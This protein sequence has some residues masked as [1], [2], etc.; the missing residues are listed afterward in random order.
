MLTRAL[1]ELAIGTLFSSPQVN[2]DLL[3]YLTNDPAKTDSMSIADLVKACRAKLVSDLD[4]DQARRFRL[5]DMEQ[6]FNGLWGNQLFSSGDLP[7]M[8]ELFARLMVR[9]GDYLQYQP[10]QVQ[11]YARLAAEIDPCLLAGWH[12]AGWLHQS[13]PL[14]DDA[15]RII[16]H[17][18]PF[19]APPTHSHKPHADGHVH[20]GGVRFDLLVLGEALFHASAMPKENKETFLRLRRLMGALLNVDNRSEDCPPTVSRQALSNACTDQ[21]DPFDNQFPDWQALRDAC[22]LRAGV[23]DADWLRWQLAQAVMN[24]QLARAWLW[25]VVYAWFLYRNMHNAP[26]VRVA[27]F[28]LFASLTQ[29]RRCLIMNGQGLSRFVNRYYE[30]PLRNASK[31]LGADVMRELMADVAD[32]AEIKIAPHKFGP[33]IAKEIAHAASAEYAL[34]IPFFNFI[35]PNPELGRAELA[36]LAQLEQWHFCAH[37]LRRKEDRQTRANLWANAEQLHDVLCNQSGWNLDA[38]LGGH[39]NHAFHFQPAYWLRGLDIAGDENLIRND[40]F[41][42]V[43]RWLRR[44][45]LPRDPIAH[46]ARAAPN[47]HLS[48]H[49]GEDYPHPLS[50]MRHI[51]ETVR[52]CELRTGDRLGHALAIGI[53]PARWVA[54]Q[55]DMVLPVDEHLDNL[56][57][58]WHYACELSARLPLANQVI[59]LLERRIARF[60]DHIPWLT[61]KFQQPLLWPTDLEETTAS[62]QQSPGKFHIAPDTLHQAWLLRRNCYHQYRCNHPIAIH[63]DML[64]M[65]VPD[66]ARLQNSD[67]AATAPTDVQTGGRGSAER[68]YLDREEN[69]LEHPDALPRVLVRVADAKDWARRDNAAGDERTFLYDFETPEE[70]QF[71]HALQDY[72]LDQYDRQGLII[73]ANP[74]SNVYIARLENHAEHPIFRWKPPDEATLANGSI[75]NQFGLRRGPIRVLVNTDDPGI[76]PTTLRTEFALLLEAAIDLGVSSTVAQVWLERLRQFGMDEFKGK[77]R[78]IFS[79]IKHGN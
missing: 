45:F 27:I 40:V 42:P 36:Y 31:G 63:S 15:A 55:G 75:H 49:V 41:A 20:L 37:F 22:I 14:P 12:L 10:I 51:D 68:I 57:W 11:A 47:F 52:F 74:S 5:N 38:F 30:A 4:R 32:V 34:P 54:R 19:F 26:D 48:I 21:V 67:A 50:G 39:A 59:P 62:A 66:Y 18:L 61:Q 58:A 24:G 6:V 17:Q 46:N 23:V 33:N 70:L 79:E 78:N 77:H 1:H 7:I 56:V 53:E 25:L 3:A 72:L 43:L 16:N 8:D 65:A 60:A 69:R 64:V 2:T 35:A 9:N 71:M 28:H 29:I 13:A 73:E 44:G 76:M